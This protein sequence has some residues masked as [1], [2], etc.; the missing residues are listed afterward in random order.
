MSSIIMQAQDI[1]KTF[2]GNPP[3]T[4]LSGVSL[5]AYSGQS[6]AIMG[7]SGEGKT[8]L[9]HILG[10]LEPPTSGKITICGHALDSTP[11]SLVR[12]RFI[13]F[14]FQAYYLLEEETVLNNVLLPLKI[15]REKTH[16]GSPAYQR[17]LMLLEELGLS[18]K[19]KQPA[20]LLSGGEKQRVTIARALA[21]DA[22]LILADEPTGNLDHQNA[23]AVQAL[24][25]N[26]VKKHQKTLILVTH[27]VDFA[28]QCDEVLL[29]KEGLLYTDEI[30]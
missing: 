2:K 29:L 4:I 17:A 15:A 11:A 22:P 8:T 5:T 26:C 18:E 25:L 23:S 21:C 9:L 1:F 3:L 28:S 27:D 10:A 24:L 16:L 13:G 14:V 7:K 20:K 12:N 19:I 30:K 6:I